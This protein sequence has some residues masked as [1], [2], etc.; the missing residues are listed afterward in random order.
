MKTLR[1]RQSLIVR[2]RSLLLSLREVEPFS[3]KEDRLALLALIDEWLK[4]DSMKS[5]RLSTFID[6][7]LLKLPPDAQFPREWSDQSK[8][9]PYRGYG[10][11]KAE[12]VKRHLEV[13]QWKKM[14]DPYIF[15]CGSLH[16]D[17]VHAVFPQLQTLYGMGQIVLWS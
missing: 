17:T 6:V 7:N 11:A 15:L 14:V 8:V 2:L 10:N 1:N 13:K 9:T 16:L 5:R 3:A 4:P 12:L